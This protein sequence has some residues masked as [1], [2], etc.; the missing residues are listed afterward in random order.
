MI[1]YEPKQEVLIVFTWSTDTKFI[2]LYVLL[3][4]MLY[5]G[6]KMANYWYVTSVRSPFFFKL[7]KSLDFVKSCSI[8]LFFE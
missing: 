2:Y 6:C 7:E 8:R 1:E 3:I 5:P 4:K